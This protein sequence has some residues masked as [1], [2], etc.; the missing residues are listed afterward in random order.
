MKHLAR[1]LT[2][3]EFDLFKAIAQTELHHKAWSESRQKQDA[4]NVLAMIDHFNRIS[5]WVGTE[6]LMK[7]SVTGRAELI[8][9]FI[10][11]ADV[12]SNNVY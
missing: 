7:E 5:Y 2:L 9:K 4:P 6:I 10:N 11:V 1:Q 8:T 12:S 3:M